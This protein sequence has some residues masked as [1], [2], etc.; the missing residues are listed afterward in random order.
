MYERRGGSVFGSFLLGGLVG[1]VLGLLFAPRSGAETRE[2]LTDRANEYWGQANEMYATGVNRVTDVMET[3]R[4]AATDRSEQLKGKIDEARAR[5]Q[6]QVAKSAEAAKGKI[7]E[8]TPAVKEAIDRT[9]EGTKS[10][11]DFATGKAHEGLDYV[12]RNL[13]AAAQQAEANAS[14]AAEQTGDE[15]EK[16]ETSKANEA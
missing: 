3:S 12:S 7:T 10:G 9:A 5:L 11:V 4:S 2:M 1:V 8:A 6:D 16:A 15:P 14:D 13:S